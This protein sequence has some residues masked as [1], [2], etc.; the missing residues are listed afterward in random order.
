MHISESGTEIDSISKLVSLVALVYG[1]LSGES[2]IDLS[3]RWNVTWFQC[4]TMLNFVLFTDRSHGN[5]FCRSFEESCV[6]IEDYVAM[7]DKEIRQRK[8]V[9]AF[10]ESAEDFYSEQFKEASIVANVSQ[11]CLHTTSYILFSIWTLSEQGFVL[12]WTFEYQFW[13]VEIWECTNRFCASQWKTSLRK[14]WQ[15]CWYWTPAFYSFNILIV[16]KYTVMIL[17][18]NWVMNGWFLQ[19]HTNQKVIQGQHLVLEILQR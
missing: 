8:I 7:L 12:K 15:K 10:S 4:W 14:V 6:K 9:L 1:T 13:M 2:V 18:Y 16:C 19:W 5:E 11:F 3:K 17:F